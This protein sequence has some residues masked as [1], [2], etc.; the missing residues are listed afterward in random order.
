MEIASAK[1]AQSMPVQR[2]DHM[3]GELGEPKHMSAGSL[4]P[5]RTA[6]ICVDVESVIQ[7]R[8][9][10]SKDQFVAGPIRLLFSS[11]IVRDHTHS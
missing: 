11:N 3:T 5:V 8:N 2:D 10:N 1:R 9:V 7:D 6:S 4:L